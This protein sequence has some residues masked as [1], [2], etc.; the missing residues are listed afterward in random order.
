MLRDI[1]FGPTRLGGCRDGYVRH[2]F[3]GL[4]MPVELGNV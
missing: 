1:V 2:G 4:S 3:Q